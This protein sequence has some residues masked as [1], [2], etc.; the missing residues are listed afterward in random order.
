MMPIITL[1]RPGGQVIAHLLHL[2][3]ALLADLNAG[4]QW[5]LTTSRDSFALRDQHHRHPLMLEPPPRE[6]A[7]GGFD[8][9]TMAV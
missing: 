6:R 7:A 4:Q 2:R 9:D 3:R 1:W 5:N 8:A